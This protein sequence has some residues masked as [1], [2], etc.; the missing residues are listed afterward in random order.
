MPTS[1][2]KNHLILG[3]QQLRHKDRLELLVIEALVVDQHILRTEIPTLE[4]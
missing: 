4:I 3:T 2:L 1:I